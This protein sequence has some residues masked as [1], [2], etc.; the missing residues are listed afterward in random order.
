MQCNYMSGD[1]AHMLLLQ[2]EYVQN[3]NP[4]SARERGYPD[5]GGGGGGDRYRERSRSPRRSVVC[6]GSANLCRGDLM[7]CRTLLLRP[8][9]ASNHH[10]HHLGIMS[11]LT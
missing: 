7:E 10:H 9:A 3:E 2:V 5:R 4:N 1:V 6:L 11:M 8:K